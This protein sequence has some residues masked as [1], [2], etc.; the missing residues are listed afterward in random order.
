[1][2]EKCM[3]KFVVLL[4]HQRQKNA[5]ARCLILEKEAYEI[6]K[7]VKTREAFV[8][9]NSHLV[10]VMS[11]RRQFKWQRLVVTFGLVFKSKCKSNERL[12]DKWRSQLKAK[13]KS[14]MKT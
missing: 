2:S 11:F 9:M 10:G 8:K 4:L 3:R 14:Y 7:L 13:G 6:N 12:D 5:V 1:M